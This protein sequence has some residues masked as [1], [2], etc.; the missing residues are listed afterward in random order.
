MYVRINEKNEIVSL[1]QVGL[2]NEG[3][4]GWCEAEEVPDEV[5]QHIFSYKFENGEFVLKENAGDIKLEKIKNAKI[6]AMSKIC[7][8]IIV[9]GFDYSDGHHY[10]LKETDQLSLGNLSVRAAQGMDSTWH[11]DGGSCQTYAPE[12]MLA[13]TKYAFDFITYHQTY[14]NQL[15]AQINSMSDID[16][17]IGIQYGMPL[18][19]PYAGNLKQVIGES[20]PP[21]A[22][23]EDRFD[24]TKILYDIAYD[25]IV[26]TVEAEPEEETYDME[27]V[28]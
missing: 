21:V 3:E 26:R 28:L 7:H 19:E 8:N 5:I 15:K 27:D 11:Y 22:L 10:S 2:P 6:A 4:P 18:I 23:T 24:Y 25:D 9:G 16:K 20:E 1:M 13:L 17:I 14:F 12:E